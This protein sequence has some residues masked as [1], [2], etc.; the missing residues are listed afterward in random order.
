MLISFWLGIFIFFAICILLT[1]LGSRI[2]KKMN[3]PPGGGGGIGF[4]VG[5]ILVIYSFVGPSRCYVVTGD[6][7]YSHYMVFGTPEYKIEGGASIT[8]NISSG[9]CFV[10]NETSG[11]IVVEEIV[12]GALFGGGTDWV[13]PGEGEEIKGGRISYFFDD[14]PPD[15]ISVS[16]GTD[17]VSKLWL[18]KRRL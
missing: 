15:E 17:E 3:K 7:E 16:E 1:Y 18:R 12:Y 10:I 5:L 14:E 6:E 2:A 13:Y 4:L 8:V 11:E 9:H